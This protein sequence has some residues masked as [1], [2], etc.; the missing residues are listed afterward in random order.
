MFYFKIPLFLLMIILGRDGAPLYQTKVPHHWTTLP[1]LENLEDTTKPIASFVIED[2][3]T[4]TVHNFPI[5]SLDDQISPLA[6]ASRWERQIGSA[7]LCLEK[8]SRNG[9]AGL[10]FEGKRDQEITLA[11]S[12]VI[13]PFLF[14]RVRYPADYTIKVKGPIDLIEKHR[15]EILEFAKYFELVQEVPC[16]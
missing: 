11:W 13:D 7:P 15:E 2:R 9:F 14:R 5:N 16:R 4:L 12:M 8:V 3:V 6:Q 10:F 1:R